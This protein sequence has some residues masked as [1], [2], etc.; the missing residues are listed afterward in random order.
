ML[1]EHGIRMDH[2]LFQNESARVGRPPDDWAVPPTYGTAVVDATH[3]LA[4]P[5]RCV[6]MTLRDPADRLASAMRFNLLN[7]RFCSK[8]AGRW[9]CLNAMLE[10]R[11]LSDFL[12]R[13]RRME[14][15][16]SGNYSVDHTWV[17]WASQAKLH[18]VWLTPQVDYLRGIEGPAGM[19]TEVRFLCVDQLNRRWQELLRSDPS[20]R[21]ASLLQLA[22]YREAGAALGHAHQR[23]NASVGRQ[24]GRWDDSVMTS[25]FGSYG[26]RHVNELTK[27]TE[28]DRQF[29]RTCLF[30]WDYQLFHAVC[31]KRPELQSVTYMPHG[32]LDDALNPPPPTTPVPNRE[33]IQDAL[34]VAAAGLDHQM[35]AELAA[36]DREYEERKPEIRMSFTK[37]R[38][39]L[40]S[41]KAL[42]DEE[43][44]LAP[45][46]TPRWPTPRRNLHLQ[47]RNP[48]RLLSPLR[49]HRP[50]ATHCHCSRAVH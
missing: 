16:R 2:T 26:D 28:Q 44:G 10:G 15:S 32:L 13:V 22:S 30:R 7:R 39:S 47:P 3:P 49:R 17:R 12:G 4:T 20:G 35:A 36:L 25:A 38:S 8:G 42:Q 21:G 43:V 29:I 41:L 50:P 11:S 33:E 31:E 27:L 45:R 37:R 18:N 34:E 1:H 23:S 40:S 48:L 24:L 6:L 9:R 14:Q 19:T 5:R 46:L